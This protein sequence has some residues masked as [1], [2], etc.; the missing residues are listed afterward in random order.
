MRISHLKARN[1]RTL[2]NIELC[3]PSF[4]SAIC[5]K[6]DSGKTNVVRAIRCLMKEERPYHDV[7]EPEFRLQDDHTKWVNTDPKSRSIYVAIDLRISAVHD[8]GLYEFFCDYLD[9]KKDKSDLDLQV[10][11]THGSDSQLIKVVAQKKKFEG[12]K[13]QEVLK[14]LQTSST[15]LFHSS[16]DPQP[17]YRR[18]FRG[19]LGDISQEYKEKLEDSKKSVDRVL[20]RIAREQQQEIGDLLGRLADK[21]KV[22]LTFP[23]FD[24]RYFPYDL[25]LGDHK[26]EVELDEWGSGTRNRTLILL[27]IF[28]AKQVSESTASASKVTP[29]IVIEEPESFLHPLAQ[30]EFGRVIQDLS[31][32][33]QVQIIVTTHSPYLL[34]QDHPESNILLKRKIVRRQLRQ[35]EHIKT[36][37]DCWMEPFV[38]A[39]GINDEEFRPWRELFFSKPKALIFV[40]GNLD[41]EYFEL[42]RNSAHGEHRLD[43]DGEIFSYGGSG[44]IKNQSILRFIKDRFG[45]VFITFD[46]DSQE[47]VEKPLLALGFKIKQSYLPIGRNAPGMRK[48]EG[49]LPDRI[50]NAVLSE[51]PDLTQALTG[52]SDERRLAERKLKKLYLEK[53]KVE[54]QPGED[55]KKLYEVARVINKALKEKS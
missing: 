55:Y 3:F 35:T 15:F 1:Y 38:L 49:L 47:L 29:V 51:N 32:E 34:S 52:T 42:L 41:K 33:F 6:N 27:T 18:G 44:T 48:I 16:T 8:T 31:E 23:S 7:D 53:F 39:L 24:L 43:F 45:R 5:G 30:A 50:R 36:D 4:Y 12:L 2:E 17:W 19:A 20:R 10:E 28:R 26:V 22:G 54:G 25:T 9:L 11:F 14:K 46:L 37:G 21:Y 13:A 40:E